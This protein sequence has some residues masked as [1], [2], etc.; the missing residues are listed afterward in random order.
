MK[1]RILQAFSSQLLFS[2][3]ADSLSASATGKPILLVGNT[4]LSSQKGYLQSIKGKAS[5][6]IYVIGGSGAVSDKVFGEVSAYASGQKV[7]VAGD[8]RYATSA[9]VA[10]KFFPGKHDSVVLAYALNYPDGL[11][12]GRVANAMNAPLL[13]AAYKKCTF[14]KKYVSE[15]GAK[16]CTVIGGTALISEAT[17]NT[18]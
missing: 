2:G 7:R 5:G 3:Y 9:A 18:I 17:L 6:N 15:H 16:K 10:D 1:L 14:A 4:L 13:L 11:S 12:G 8:T